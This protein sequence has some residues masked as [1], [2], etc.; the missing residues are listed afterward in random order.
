MMELRPTGLVPSGDCV[1]SRQITIPSVSPCDEVVVDHCQ[2]CGDGDQVTQDVP[3][4]GVALDADLLVD[5]QRDQG[6]DQHGVEH[7]RADHTA[8]AD[9]ILPRA[10]E[11]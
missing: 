7:G 2:Q 3:Q 10:K 6:D 8:D 5:Q 11:A 4:H 9:V 1:V